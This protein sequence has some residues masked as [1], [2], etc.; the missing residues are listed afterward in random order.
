MDVAGVQLR[1]LVDCGVQAFGGAEDCDL[2]LGVLW[3][4]VLRLEK[5][6]PALLRVGQLYLWEDDQLF[7]AVVVQH[8]LL[9]VLVADPL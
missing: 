3:D 2:V 5:G 1:E 6:H 8:D 4:C 7:L 9:A